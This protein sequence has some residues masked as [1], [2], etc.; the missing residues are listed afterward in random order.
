MGSQRLQQRTSCKGLDGQ[1]CLAMEVNAS[2]R[3]LEEE[4]DQT[5]ISIVYL[6]VYLLPKSHVLLADG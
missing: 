3:S 1:S 2:D 5:D 6:T 4:L